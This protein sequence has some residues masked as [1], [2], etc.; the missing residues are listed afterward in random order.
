MLKYKAGYK[1]V[2]GIVHAQ[3]IDFPAAISSGADLEDARRMLGLALL[4]V[5]QAHFE[6]GQALPMPDA[7]ASDPEMDVEEPIYLHLT[8][9]SQLA[10]APA[11]VVVP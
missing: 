7:T 10:Q 6:L 11:G 2:E 1:F 9:S 3:V 8:V 5:A 4:D